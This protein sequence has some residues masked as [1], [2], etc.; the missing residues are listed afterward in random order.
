MEFIITHLHRTIYW[1]AWIW[2]SEN[3][4]CNQIHI[5]R[6]YVVPLCPCNMRFV[7]WAP[8]FF[9]SVVHQGWMRV[10]CHAAPQDINSNGKISLILKWLRPYN[11]KNKYTGKCN[12][13]RPA[14]II[15]CRPFWLNQ[16]E[17]HFCLNYDDVTGLRVWIYYPQ[18]TKLASWI[19]NISVIL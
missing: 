12:R 7:V 18:K 3:R 5:I 17:N 6:V 9:L 15:K 19:S 4:K 10:I 11:V 8:L 14:S 13:E 2:C 1:T 16:R